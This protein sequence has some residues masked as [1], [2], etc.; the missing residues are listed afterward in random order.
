MIIFCKELGL[1]K[2]MVDEY[3]VRY[4]NSLEILVF[5]LLEKLDLNELE[6]SDGCGLGFRRAILEYDDLAEIDSLYV[7]A[8]EIDSFYSNE[9]QSWD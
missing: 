7:A 8:C 4:V 6:P 5:E 2:V 1:A 3:T 9:C